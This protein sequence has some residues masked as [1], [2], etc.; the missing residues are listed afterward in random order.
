[1][2]HLCPNFFM[3]YSRIILDS[4]GVKFPTSNI[5]TILGSPPLLC[6]PGPSYPLAKS[7][8]NG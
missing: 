4:Y 1:M 5:T 8:S 7:V 6:I 2:L 3:G